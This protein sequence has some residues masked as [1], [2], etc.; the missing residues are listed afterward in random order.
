MIATGKGRGL[1]FAWGHRW[2]VRHGGTDRAMVGEKRAQGDDSE[3]G[4]SGIELRG[5][6][7]FDRAGRLLHFLGSR[8]LECRVHRGAVFLVRRDEVLQDLHL[9]PA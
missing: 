4:Y 8:E 7:D 9:G 6:T 3:R 2:R 5:L 1:G